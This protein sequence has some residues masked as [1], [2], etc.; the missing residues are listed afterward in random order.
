MALISRWNWQTKEIENGRC[1]VNQVS[2]APNR[3]RF[4][5]QTG[6]D[7]QIGHTK[8]LFPDAQR[9]AMIARVFAKCLAVVAQNNKECLLIKPALPQS[10]QESTEGGVAV[11][12][13][14]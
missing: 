4:L 3:Q 10:L 7:Y 11:V 13:S 6:C 9:M 5:D 1:R 12:Q 14:I 8:V 2:Q